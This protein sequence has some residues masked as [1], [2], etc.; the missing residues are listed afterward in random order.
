MIDKA[1]NTLNGKPIQEW[2]V[3][4]RTYQ[5]LFRTQKAAADSAEATE[6]PAEMIRPIPVAITE[7]GDYEE[8]P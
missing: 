8:A 3:W 1:K 5:G 7:N 2:V 6:L 4:F